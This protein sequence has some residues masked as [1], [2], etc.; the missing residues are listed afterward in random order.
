MYTTNES[1]VKQQPLTVLAVYYFR[2]KNFIS[3]VQIGS[4]QASTHFFR[5]KIFLQI[6]KLNRE[7]KQSPG[8]IVQKIALKDFLKFTERQQSPF[9]QSYK[10]VKNNF[11]I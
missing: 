2:K 5:E 1:F 11:F 7:Q 6:E 3:D 4:K 10:P 9:Q 8:G